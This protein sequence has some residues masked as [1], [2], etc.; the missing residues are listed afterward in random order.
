M[1]GIATISRRLRFGD[2]ELEISSGQLVKNGSRVLLRGQPLEV[3][4]VLLEHPG[5]VVTREELRRRLWRDDVFVDFDNNLNTAIARL[6]DV[7]HDSA[8]QPQFIETLPKLGYR[9]IADVAEAAARRVPPTSGRPRLLVLPFVNLSADQ[10]KEYF[11]DAMTEEII[12]ALATLAADRLAVIARTTS[13]HY[14]GSRQDLGSIGRE[15]TVD[16]IV[17]GSVRLDPDGFV[18][19]LQ[20]VQVSDQSHL[21]AGRYEAKAR[22]VFRIHREAAQAIAERTGAVGVSKDALPA[23]RQPTQDPVAYNLYVQG[24]YHLNQWT[25]EG[26]VRA[27]EFFEKATQRD[28]Q[29]ALAYNS[30]AE[31]YWFAGFFGYVPPLDVFRVGLFAAMRAFEIDPTSAETLG[32]IAHYR[33]QCDYDWPEA[34]RLVRRG[35]ELSPDSLQLQLDLASLILLTYGRVEEAAV[36]IE[37]ILERDPLSLTA[38]GWLS[39]V[40]GLARQFDRS[41][42]EARLIIEMAPEYW[43]GHWHEGIS[44]LDRGDMDAGVEA[45]RKASKFSADSPLMLGWLGMALARSGRKAEALGILERLRQMNSKIYVPPSGYAWI[46][47]ALGEFDEA[48]TWLDRSIEMHDPFILPL[49]T[50]PWLDPVRSDPRYLAVLRKLHLD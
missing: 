40:Y 20:L 26:L 6:Q 17:E 32:L 46:H 10:A 13:M 9:F 39:A 36:M 3:L 7:L 27:R 42:D 28:P 15:L 49:K 1:Q 43:L 4:A 21:W 5:E 16:Y 24:R 35:L 34:E 41:V 12:A 29:F 22:D 14:K 8:Q 2:F 19:H 23:Q 18:V 11:S 25:N 38:R 48:F 30:L 37:R 44:L 33:K 50:Y 45:I 31:L 47:Y